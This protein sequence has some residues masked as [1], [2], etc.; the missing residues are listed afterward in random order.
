MEF[1]T[2]QDSMSVGI[3]VIDQDHKIIMRLINFSHRQLIEHHEE[4]VLSSALNALIDYTLYHFAREEL[5]MKACDYPSIGEHEKLHQ[6]LTKQVADIAH[7]YHE[8]SSSIEP[9]IFLEFLKN[10]LINHI[11]K[12]DM[13]FK[14]YCQDNENL[15]TVIASLGSNQQE[16]HTTE[17]DSIIPHEV[18]WSK[19]NILII[20]E[21]P[22]FAEMLT[23]IL[24]LADVDNI[25]HCHQIGE[26]DGINMSFSPDVI[27]L[28]EPILQEGYYGIAEQINALENTA[29]RG[30]PVLLICAN[31]E[32]NIPSIVNQTG[33]K[34]CINEPVGIKILLEAI[35]NTLNS[36]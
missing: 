18:N 20:S 3:P 22:N 9:E 24:E 36:L 14:P 34:H 10:W 13:K 21:K 23:S 6:D 8:D 32:D 33:V 28:Q 35:A 4:K 30:T 5:V 2:W 1:I 16:A 11:L 25:A 31:K 19:T 26:I 7:R 27:I 15:A 12:Q 17:I 29:A